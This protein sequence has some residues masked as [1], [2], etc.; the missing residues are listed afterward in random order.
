MNIDLKQLE[1]A[2]EEQRR[3]GWNISDKTNAILAKAARAYLDMA[4]SSRRA[5]HPSQLTDDE[6]DLIAKSKMPDCDMQV[7][8]DKLNAIYKIHIGASSLDKQDIYW[9][10]N[11]ADDYIT[12]LGLW[13]GHNIETIRKALTQSPPEPTVTT[14]TDPADRSQNVEHEQDCAL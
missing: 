6:V 7:V 13:A 5:L 14:P 11:V 2:I 4:K 12:Q 8:L 3:E 9:F 1:E 10:D